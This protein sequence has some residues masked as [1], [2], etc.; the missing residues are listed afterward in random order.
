MKRNAIGESVTKALG[1]LFR[2]QDESSFGWSWIQDITPNA[3]NTAEIVHACCANADLLS[4]TQKELLTEAVGQWMLKPKLNCELTVDFVWVLLG[5]LSYI[6]RMGEFAPVEFGKEELEAAVR[7]CVYVLLERQNDDGGFADNKTDRSTAIRSALALLAFARY[8]EQ[9]KSKAAFVDPACTKLCAWLKQ[10]QNEDGGWGNVSTDVI[11]KERALLEDVP[12]KERVGQVLSNAAAT[13][14]AL[15]AMSC[16]DRA[17]F[18][19]NIKKGVEFLRGI[20][21]QD[22]GFPLFVEVGV[23]KDVIFTYRHFGTSWALSG[24]LYSGECRASDPLIIRTVYNLLGLQDGANGGWRC[25]HESDIYTWSTANAITA[26]ARI[27]DARQELLSREY[28]EI[29]ESWWNERLAAAGNAPAAAEK[30]EEREKTDEPRAHA[31]KSFRKRAV[32]WLKTGRWKALLFFA[33]AAGLLIAGK[34]ELAIA[35]LACA[36]VAAI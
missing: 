18:S 15:T 26:L 27:G 32:E 4:D 5:L 2:I 9:Y 17:G 21:A 7:E 22:G 28:A 3:Q 12:E 1:W 11:H 23:R 8:K 13:G 31:Q 24:L 34:T 16:F 30:P 33:A 25:T 6:K 14:Y 20:Q 36:A 19:E 35:F 29:Y 10:R